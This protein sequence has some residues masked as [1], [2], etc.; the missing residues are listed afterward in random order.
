MTPWACT[1][2]FGGDRKLEDE[3]AGVQAAA[4]ESLALDAF[5]DGKGKGRGKGD[6]TAIA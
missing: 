2:W 1:P 3:H 5:G 4:S 6:G